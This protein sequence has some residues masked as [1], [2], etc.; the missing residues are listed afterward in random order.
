[1]S[2]ESDRHLEHPA[3]HT[4]VGIKSFPTALLTGL[5]LENPPLPAGTETSGTD[6]EVI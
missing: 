6:H 5:Y 2:Q 1:M 3:A 4:G